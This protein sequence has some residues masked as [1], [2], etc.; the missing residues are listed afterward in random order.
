MKQVKQEE[1]KGKK[2]RERKKE[3][4]EG[5]REKERKKTRCSLLFSRSV[6]SN[7]LQPHELQQARFLPGY[8]QTHVH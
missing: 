5:G 2:E 3:E 1:R 4:R 8:A 6:M 7:S